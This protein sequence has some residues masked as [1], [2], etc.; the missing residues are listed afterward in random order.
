MLTIY[1]ICLILLILNLLTLLGQ[2]TDDNESELVYPVGNDQVDNIETS[3]G[4]ECDLLLA[5]FCLNVV[6]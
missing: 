1:S 3:H 6:R 5:I 2:C 4:S